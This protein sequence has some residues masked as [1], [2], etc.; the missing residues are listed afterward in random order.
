MQQPA[1]NWRV[2]IV[3]LSVFRPELRGHDGGCG[4]TSIRLTLTQR[5]RC[6]KAQQTDNRNSQLVLAITGQLVHP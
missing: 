1:P 3:N 4:V 2:T 6:G 5:A